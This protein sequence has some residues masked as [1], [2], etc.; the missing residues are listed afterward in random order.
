MNKIKLTAI[1]ALALFT[2]NSANAQQ[3][4]YQDASLSPTER[5]QDLCKRL[6]LDEKVSLMMDRSPAIKR[7]G[8][9]QFQW[10]N[11]ALHGVGRNGFATVFPITVGMAASFDDA[12]VYDVFTAVSDEAR[13]KANEATRSGN[14]DRYQSLSFWTP[15]IN[16]FRDP[17][18]GRGQETYGEDPYLTTKMGL[19]VIRGLEGDENYKYKKLLACA[20][21]FAVHSGPEWNRHSF[22]LENVEPRDLWETYMPAFK[23]AVQEGHVSEVMCAYQRLDGEPCCGNN[24]LLQQIL[25]GEWGF[26]GMVV[27]DCSAISDFW[28]KGRHGVSRNAADASAKAVLAGTDVEC[29]SNYKGLPEAVK[30]GEITE[31]QID[32]SIVRLLKARFELGDFD[33]PS[34]N[35]YRSIPM[36]IVAD[37]AKKALA[38]KV[39]RE[40]VVLLQNNDNILP[41]SASDNNIVVMGPNAT[42]SVM[43]WGNYSGYPTRT[44]T[45]L[46]G[47][48]EKNPNIKYVR[49]C[50]FTRNEVSESRYGEISSADGQK[51]MKADYWNNPELSGTPDK[52][53][54]L[55]SGVNL[56]NGGATVFAPGIN[57]D[58]MSA[59][60]TGTFVPTRSERVTFTASF[61]DGARLIINGDTVANVWKSR[62]RIQYINKDMDVVAGQKYDIQLD[63]FQK[64]D[65]GA[66]QFDILHKYTPTREQLLAEIGNADKVVFVGGISP[67]LEGEEMKVSDPGFK[68][69][70]RT[71]IQ[72]PEAQ[73]KLVNM[74]HDAGKKVIFV[75]C[76]GSAIGLEPESQNS[77]A[78]VQAWYPGEMGGRAVADVLYGDYNPDGKLPI[79]FYRHDS[80]LPDFMDYSMKNRTYRYFKGDALFPFGYGLSYTSF[81]IQ[82][83]GF[84]KGNAQIKVT[85]TGS[86]AGTETV[87]MYIR[88]IADTEGPI[89]SLRG[90]KRVNLNPGETTTIEIP[91]LDKE[92]L[93]TWDS[94][95]NTVRFV[96]GKY[97]IMI[98]SSSLDKDL[99][100][101]VVTIKKL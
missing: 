18:W 15:N 32:T 63:Y 44:I 28:V 59:R 53:V 87:Q 54:Q 83:V 13:A 82:P 45:I 70:D 46:Q 3:Y 42:D 81:D 24:R 56:S 35:K 17:R 58:N 23:A 77:E 38:L 8:I 85:N 9:P 48:R 16:I 7:L 94:Q 26:K 78:I 12:L 27:S 98:G 14:I 30:A 64:T 91:Y 100:K 89:K 50:D 29:G 51:G 22:N 36:S 96:P 97:E 67:R 6:T 1:F 19:A 34:L 72:L 86:K 47:I 61:D 66:V 4:P 80:D 40:A 41:L 69:G 76:S 10:W 90:Y 95:T 49:G 39:A 62:A 79:T 92:V 25:R 84:K 93:E 75:N 73:R 31:S 11:E 43:Q 99:T 88:R 74:L 65:M 68:G 2:T 52:T 60:F 55:S 71:S 57:L 101:K 37:N 21:H 33:D 5:A 20:K